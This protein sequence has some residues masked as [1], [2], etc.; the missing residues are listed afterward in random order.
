MFSD[1][2]IEVVTTTDQI[3]YIIDRLLTLTH[4][5]HINILS[6]SKTITIEMIY[7]RIMEFDKIIENTGLKIFHLE[8]ICSITMSEYHDLPDSINSNWITIIVSDEKLLNDSSNILSIP[9]F[10]NTNSNR[11]KKIIGKIIFINKKQH[12]NN[13]SELFVPKITFVKK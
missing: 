2:E 13:R 6:E 8:H 9:F 11:I 7:K 5:T 10:D 12:G 4:G 1:F 3:E